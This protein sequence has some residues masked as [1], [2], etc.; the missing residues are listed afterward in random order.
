MSLPSPSLPHPPRVGVAVIDSGVNPRSN[1]LRQ[2][3]REISVLPLDVGEPER[4]YDGQAGVW[5]ETEDDD[6]SQ[7]G[8]LMCELLQGEPPQVDPDLYVYRI[9][10]VLGVRNGDG[11][12]ANHVTSMLIGAFRH[13]LKRDEIHVVNVSLTVDLTAPSPGLVRALESVLRSMLEGGRLVF[14]AVGN[15]DPTVAQSLPTPL[16][17]GARPGV[18]VGAAYPTKDGG[19]LRHELS[20][21]CHL[22]NNDYV[23]DTYAYSRVFCPVIQ[24]WKSGTSAATA[25]VSSL[26]ARYVQGRLADQRTL[27]R[28]DVHD[29]Y[30]L[31]R[32]T[33]LPVTDPLARPG[34]LRLCIPPNYI[35]P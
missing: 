22:A 11:E 31:L 34:P 2:R 16:P 6:T 10:N 17:G 20:R 35:L 29:I 26:V 7:H 15:A 19:W 30:A 14:M 12:A 23:P 5:S 24:S 8:T 32:R 3:V 28:A 9:P 4:V 18:T 25:R 21:S 33:G 27:T 1:W 13:I